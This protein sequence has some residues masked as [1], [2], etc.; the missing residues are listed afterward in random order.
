MSDE[1]TLRPRGAKSDA[2]VVLAQVIAA[3]PWTEHKAGNSVF[4]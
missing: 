4:F 1:D 2:E 3:T